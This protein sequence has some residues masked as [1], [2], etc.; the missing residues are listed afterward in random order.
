MAP[1]TNPVV[2][3]CSEATL[4]QHRGRLAAE[5]MRMFGLKQVPTFDSQITADQNAGMIVHRKVAW[6]ARNRGIG[7]VAVT[8]LPIEMVDENHIFWAS[9]RDLWRVATTRAR[10]FLSADLTFFRGAPASVKTQIFRVEW[11][12]PRRVNGQIAF[13]P[14]LAAHPHWQFDYS[15]DRQ[16]PFPGVFVP[17]SD[18]DNDVIEFSEATVVPTSRPR[19]VGSERWRRMHF[20][21]RAHWAHLRF[22]STEEGATPHAHAPEDCAQIENWV[23][24]TLAYVMKE[25]STAYR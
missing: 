23:T 14:P 18:P 10:E 20:A 1:M 2:L 15:E 19:H 9:Y 22:I 25:L 21:A 5:L 24:S 8:Q 13:S 6:V 16:D 12:G 17:T 3:R 11:S 7:D 4:R